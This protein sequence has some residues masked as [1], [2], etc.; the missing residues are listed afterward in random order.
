MPTK[1]SHVANAC[2]RH[3]AQTF[4]SRVDHCY[5]KPYQFYGVTLAL[6]LLGQRK[7]NVTKI[8]TSSS[9]STIPSCV[10]AAQLRQKNE[11]EARVRVGD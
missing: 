1:V 8:S 6:A 10:P 4:R 7:T 9:V 5:L 11:D 3:I 2:E